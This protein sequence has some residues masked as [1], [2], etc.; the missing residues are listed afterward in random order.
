[1]RR[2]PRA[3]GV[4]RTRWSLSLLRGQLPWLRL[5]SDGGMHRLLSRLGISWQRARSYIHSPD[6]SYAAKLSGVAAVRLLSRQAPDA[7]V[8]LYLDEVTIE[9]QPSLAQA[10]EQRGR[11]ASQPLARWSVRANTLT[12]VVAT[13]GHHDA[14]VVFKRASS[15]RLATLVEFYQQVC[16]AYAWA[17]RIYIIADNWPVHWHPDVLIALEP[18]E[19]RYR[20]QLPANWPAEASATAKRK[21]GELHLPIQLVPLPTYASWCNPIEKLW[22]KLRQELMHLHGWADDLPRLRNEIDQFLTQFADGS[23]DLLRYVGLCPG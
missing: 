22:R 8:T 20:G 14:R 2:D 13:L 3:C 21:W 4:G 18:Q 12:R 11:R 6:P 19:S 7:L 16:T 9:R 15:I 10:Y 1:M 23:P 5:H 17:E